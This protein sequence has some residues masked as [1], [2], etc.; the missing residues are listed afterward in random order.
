MAIGH[1]VVVEGA[2]KATGCTVAVAAVVSLLL[3][4]LAAVPE[5]EGV[6]LAVVAEEP[7]KLDIGGCK[8][9]SA[10]DQRL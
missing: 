8:T 9:Q 2:T 4:A 10:N 3:V 7:W 1:Q 6:G 5:I